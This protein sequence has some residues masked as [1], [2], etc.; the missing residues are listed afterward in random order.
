[1]S[2]DLRFKP[3][4]EPG[5]SRIFASATLALIL[6]LSACGGGS[7]DMSGNLASAGEVL[8]AAREAL[9][10]L[11]SYRVETHF[12]KTDQS[13]GRITSSGTMTVAWSAPDRIHVITEGSEEGEETQRSEYMSTD[14]RVMVRHSTS[15]DIWAVYSADGNADD[16]APAGI[17]ALMEMY[18]TASRFLPDMEEAELAGKTM[19]D[20][21][22]VYHI[23]GRS[24][25]RLLPREDWPAE[26]EDD[27]PTQQNDSTFDLYTGVDDLLPRRLLSVT[28]ITYTAS[29]LE[30]S[31]IER[32][33]VV[34]TA[35]FLDLNAPVIIE[36]PEVR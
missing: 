36:L 5:L 34:T 2:L 15:G 35:E 1:M 9:S 32:R 31:G 30:G 3:G 12:V 11:T 10:S 14:G 19:I 7:P 18:S 4:L 16:G 23:K 33:R 17:L 29:R 27:F 24:N 25:V 28:D 13:S 22:G 21:L 20:G 8:A 26:V 6:F